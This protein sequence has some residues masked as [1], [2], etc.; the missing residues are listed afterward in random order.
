VAGDVVIGAVERAIRVQR[1]YGN[2]FVGQVK[3]ASAQERLTK[4]LARHPVPIML[5]AYLAIATSWL[6]KWLGA[7][8]LRTRCKVRFRPRI[9]PGLV[10]SRFTPKTTRQD[11]LRTFRL[12][13]VAERFKLSIP[14]AQ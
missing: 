6:G 10:R 14:A 7:G 8:L 4:L 5:L 9:L 13:S 1:T 12:Q 2:L 3:Y 11:H